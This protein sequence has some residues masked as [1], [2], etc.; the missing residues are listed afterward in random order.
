MAL[1]TLISLLIGAIALFGMLALN[2]YFVAETVAPRG[3]KALIGVGVLAG[4]GTA[5]FVYALVRIMADVS[6]NAWLTMYCIAVAVSFVV[7]AAY[8]CTQTDRY[9]ALV[10]EALAVKQIAP[11]LLPRI[12]SKAKDAISHQDLREALKRPDWSDAERRV[13]EHMLSEIDEIGH[14]V[15]GRS[16]LTPTSGLTAT[17]GVVYDVIAESGRRISRADIETYPERRSKRWAIWL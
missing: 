17:G 7:P 4:I 8:N 9:R 16:Y 5:L 14:M 3:K 6:H 12:G 13:L 1:N 2:G 11:G 15:E 10:V